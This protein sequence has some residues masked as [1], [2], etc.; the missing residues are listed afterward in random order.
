MKDKTSNIVQV[1]E[2]IRNELILNIDAVKEYLTS[3]LDI[4]KGFWEE[5]ER[6][7]DDQDN[8]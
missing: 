3:S 7:D 8:V 2:Q 6:Q 5:A 1:L 4:I